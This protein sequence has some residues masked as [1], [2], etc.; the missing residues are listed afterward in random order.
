[1]VVDTNTCPDID[2]TDANGNPFVQ[3]QLYLS[4]ANQN[5]YEVKSLDPDYLAVK[6]QDQQ[7]PLHYHTVHTFKLTPITEQEVLTLAKNL[8]TKA[9]G[10]E[11]LVKGRTSTQE[12]SQPTETGG[13][14]KDWTTKP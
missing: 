7:I 2:Y 10:L 14:H 6:Y 1:M 8:R 5:V 12:I 9:D 3:G 13:D 11:Q 4:G